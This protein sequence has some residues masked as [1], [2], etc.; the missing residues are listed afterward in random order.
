M[1]E[2]KTP[3]DRN[4]IIPYIQMLEKEISVLHRKSK[5]SPDEKLKLLEI[6]CRIRIMYKKGREIAW[7]LES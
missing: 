1:A 2:N 3:L 4:N 6:L 5:I 7:G